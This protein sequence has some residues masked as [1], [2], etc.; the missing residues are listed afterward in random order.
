MYDAMGSYL[1]K[2]TVDYVEDGCR[3]E[4]RRLPIVRHPGAIV[5]VIR[6]TP[7][8]LAAAAVHESKTNVAKTQD[9]PRLA[10]ARTRRDRLGRGWRRP[11]RPC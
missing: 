8:P 7:S 2:F 11:R 10:G 1:L 3:W 4:M 9:P 6:S 5:E